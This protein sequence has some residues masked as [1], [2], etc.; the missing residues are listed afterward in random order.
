MNKNIGIIALLSLLFCNP[1]FSDENQC[2]NSFKITPSTEYK[3]S[4]DRENTLRKISPSFFSFNIEWMDFQL[5]MWDTKSK[6]IKPQ[7]LEM[8]RAF[9]GA[10]YRYHDGTGSDYFDWHDAVG[11][12]E[13]RPLRKYAS[14]LQPFSIE[15]GPEE[16][17]KFVQD[18]GGKAW[19]I[20]NL[21]GVNSQKQLPTDK[22]ANSAGELAEFMQKENASGLPA[23][24][25]WELDNELDRGS[26]LWSPQKYTDAAYSV[27]QS[28]QNKQHNAMFAPFLEEFPAMLKAGFTS[29]QY[30][31]II[32]TKLK[33]FTHEYAMHTY[34]DGDLS[35]KWYLNTV[36]NALEDAKS[37]GVSNPTV[38]VTEN[39]R[40]PANFWIP[41]VEEQKKLWPQTADLQAAI[42]VADMMIA[43]TQIPEIN[44][45]FIHALHASGGPWPLYHTQASGDIEPSVVLWGLRIFRE[46]LLPEVFQTNIQ[47]ANASA[48]NGGYDVRAVV[49]TDAKRE[50][51]S[52]W[53]I[54]RSSKPTLVTM[55]LPINNL[56][57]KSF[58]AQFTTISNSDLMANNY[59][60][61]RNVI[62]VKSKIVISVDSSA[63][64]KIT[65]PQY[66]ISTYEIDVNKKN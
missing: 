6:T 48:Y 10:I 1:A 5:S 57:S 2:T 53:A 27:A 54:N 61:Y 32:A 16:Y 42:S 25:R 29:K 52:I 11:S 3:L 45:L 24:L 34:Y 50:H 38:W 30:N 4:I 28:I 20:A 51:F 65:L 63:N 41:K 26:V 66:S 49:L 62:P 21:Y 36:C 13:T 37:A 47:S 14:W 12:F 59:K 64:S 8:M 33:D 15:F 43:S 55:N 44:G 22:M 58:V 7:A 17:L 39:A 35:M 23:I 60:D 19:Y 18:V 56:K 40:V 31:Q 9:S 46:S